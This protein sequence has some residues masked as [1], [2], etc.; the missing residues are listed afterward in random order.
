MAR[1]QL[2]EMVTA[3]ISDLMK[4]H[5]EYRTEARQDLQFLSAQKL[6]EHEADIE[7]IKSVFLAIL[8]DIKNDMD[9]GEQPGETITT[10]M[11][12]NIQNAAKE[13]KQEIHTI[14]DVTELVAEQIE[15]VMSLDEEMSEQFRQLAKKMME[16]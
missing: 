2:I 7:K 13:Q 14:D 4:T 1:N 15:K 3:S 5:P 11:L 16:Q 9:S 8:R 10:A 6:G 12:Q